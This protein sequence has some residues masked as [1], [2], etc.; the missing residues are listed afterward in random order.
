MEIDFGPQIRELNL[1]MWQT[2]RDMARAD[3]ALARRNFG[4]TLLQATRLAQMTNL[5]VQAL[6]DDSKPQWDVAQARALDLIMSSVIANS[7]D[8]RLD[9]YRL[10]VASS[11]IPYPSREDL[12]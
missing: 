4:L 5:Q 9:I 7:S 11:A 1:L 2:A 3:V 12:G 8:D 6:A 10:S